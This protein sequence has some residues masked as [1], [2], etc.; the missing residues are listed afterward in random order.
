[1]K[2]IT[3]T[4]RQLAWRWAL[5]AAVTVVLVACDEGWSNALQPTVAPIPVGAN[6]AARGSRSNWQSIASSS[7][8]IKLVAA[9][10]N[11]QLYTSS[12]SG[13][14][15]TARDSNR[16]WKSVASSSDGQVASREAS[17]DLP[18]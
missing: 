18:S 9:G 4:I 2:F 7:D 5:L 12:D 14:T 1:M 15:W 17:L 6:W 16:D 8:G 13:A 10:A 3:K 11:G